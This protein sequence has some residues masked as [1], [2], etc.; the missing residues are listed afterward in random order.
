M[1]LFLR[2][3]RPL[4]HL[5]SHK[6]T[7]VTDHKPLTAILNPQK[8][9]SSLAAVRLQQWARI[10]SAHSYDIEFLSTGEHDSLSRLP[11][12]G[13]PPDDPYSDPNPRSVFSPGPFSVSA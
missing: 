9:I 2:H 13:V 4:R 1:K 5:Y 12:D 11:I 6:L 3:M 8:G 10:L 7:L